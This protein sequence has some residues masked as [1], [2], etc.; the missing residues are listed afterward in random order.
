MRNCR[1]PNSQSFGHVD[2]FERR[3]QALRNER[4]PHARP[5]DRPAQGQVVA[6]RVRPDLRNPQP[7][8]VLDSNGHR[9]A[10]GVVEGTIAEELGHGPI[11]RRQRQGGRD[12]CSV[13]TNQRYP[14]VAPQLVRRSG[15]TSRP[16]QSRWTQ[17]SESAKARTSVSSGARWYAY[18]R[19]KIFWPEALGWAGDQD[20]NVEGVRVRASRLFQRM[21]LAVRRVG[22]A[23]DHE[24]Q[25]VVLV[26]LL[27]ERSDVRMEAGVEAL[28]GDDQGRAGPI[29]E[30]PLGGQLLRYVVIV[31]DRQVH[32]KQLDRERR[33]GYGQIPVHRHYDSRIAAKDQSF[34]AGR[35]PHI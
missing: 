9:A 5:L 1:R 8:E 28:A 34:S 26:V 23:L 15:R 7:A 24:E 27:E 20:L 11:D 29:A 12:C 32:R 19:L 33:T 22:F 16:S 14:V 31:A 21:Q 30:A 17:T 10:P 4:D 2:G 35:G 25:A 3:D 18:S 13:G 6:E